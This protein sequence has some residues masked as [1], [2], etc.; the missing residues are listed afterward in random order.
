M[1]TF[2]STLPPAELLERLRS[3]GAEWRGS[4]MRP[5]QEFGRFEIC[6]IKI[7]S[8]SFDLILDPQARGPLVLWRGEVAP[9]DGG[10]G[11]RLT[12]F[13]RQTSFSRVYLGLFCCLPLIAGLLVSLGVFG[14]AGGGGYG[15]TFGI[16]GSLLFAALVQV[17]FAMQVD[18]QL[19]AVRAILESLA[20]AEG[21][22]MGP[23]SPARLERN[24]G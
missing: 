2:D 13:P 6:R 10:V 5:F 19:T 3:F 21:G 18:H 11:S 23:P 8:N 1:I 15:W 17:S 16:L 24:R 7:N 12:A 22:L 9:G 20:K 4:K 14:Q